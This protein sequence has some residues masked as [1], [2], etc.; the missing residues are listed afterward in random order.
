MPKKKKG[1]T[2]EDEAAEEAEAVELAVENVEL[3]VCDVTGELVFPEEEKRKY[4]WK[5]AT[6]CAGEIRK[7][8]ME[9]EE[10]LAK[11]KKAKKKNANKELHL[12]LVIAMLTESAQKRI[13]FEG[14]LAKRSGMDGGKPPKARMFL[15][16]VT[17]PFNKE[18]G[19]AWDLV[20]TVTL[21]YYDP[22][23]GQA[24]GVIQLDADTTCEPGDGKTVQTGTGERFINSATSGIKMTCQDAIPAGRGSDAGPADTCTHPYWFNCPDQETRDSWI[25]QINTAIQL[26]SIMCSASQKIQAI[27]RGK[28]IRASAMEQLEAKKKDA[29]AAYQY[30]GAGASAAAQAGAQLYAAKVPQKQKDYIKVK[31]QQTAARGETRGSSPEDAQEIFMEIDFAASRPGKNGIAFGQLVQWWSVAGSVEV[32]DEDIAAAKAI[33]EETDTDGADEGVGLFLA[34]FTTVVAKMEQ[35]GLLDTVWPALEKKAAAVGASWGSRTAA[36]LVAGTTASFGM[37]ASQSVKQKG[38]GYLKKAKSAA[39]G[40]PLVSAGGTIYNKQQPKA[41]RAFDEMQAAAATARTELEASIGPV[42][43]N[44]LAEKYGAE[45]FLEIDFSSARELG[46]GVSYGQFLQWLAETGGVWPTDEHMAKAKAVW[47]EFETE[48]VTGKHGLLCEP[49]IGCF[50]KMQAEGVVDTAWSAMASKAKVVGPLWGER[51]A[52]SLSV[53]SAAAFRPKSTISEGVPPG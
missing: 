9:K 32:S 16:V 30:A 36:S 40:T 19:P 12:E 5:Y 45:A 2:P 48:D 38:G 10:K 53:G 49:F 24:K 15:L 20:P 7:K 33:W 42:G 50:T 52:A 3:V 4:L 47:A 27:Q 51:N 13:R 31:A 1:S 23:W 25:Q 39:A 21:E 26:S 11:Q 35:E 6:I 17:P 44:S 29:I 22:K 8:I 28:A 37:K 41:S 34:D 46:K 43:M 14:K 18:T